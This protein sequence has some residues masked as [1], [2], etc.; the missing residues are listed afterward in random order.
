[1]LKASWK[2][3]EERTKFRNGYVKKMK[4]LKVHYDF[5]SNRKQHISWLNFGDSNKDHSV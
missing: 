3:K 1:M 4:I 2:T 5:C